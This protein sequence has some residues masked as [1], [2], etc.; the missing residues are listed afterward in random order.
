[1]SDPALADVLG[2]LGDGDS[3]IFDYEIQIADSVGATDTESLRITLNGDDF[4][5]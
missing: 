4:F 5:A 2:G 3:L 1:M